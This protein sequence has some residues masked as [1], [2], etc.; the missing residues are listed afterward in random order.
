MK[1]YFVQTKYPDGEIGGSMNTSQQIIDMFGESNKLTEDELITLHNNKT[2]ALIRVSAQLGCL[3]A[4]FFSDSPE[5]AAAEAYANRV[6]LAFQIVDDILDATST[7]EAMGKSV[8]SDAA[9]NK[10]T[11]LSFHT[12]EEAQAMADRMTEEAVGAI[13]D[14]PASDRLCA[15]AAYLAVRK[16]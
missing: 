4:G 13:K 6:G 15:V 7:P 9:H 16:H 10:N 8:G 11:F 5:M 14:L 2:G 12:I 1:K 3:A